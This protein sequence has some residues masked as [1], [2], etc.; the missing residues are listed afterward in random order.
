MPRPK[1]SPKSRKAAASVR[2]ARWRQRI[3]S[4]ATS[5]HQAGDFIDFAS[6]SGPISDIAAGTASDTIGQV[7]AAG[8][9]GEYEYYR[10]N[11]SQNYS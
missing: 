4:R 1:L 2:T 7:A 11:Y 5:S 10:R 3:A 8:T 9:A 6:T